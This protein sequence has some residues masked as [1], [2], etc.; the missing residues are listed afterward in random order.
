MFT[1]F[2]NY[3]YSTKFIF[4]KFHKLKQLQIIKKLYVFD[5]IT[6]S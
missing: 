5:K 4:H 3:T 1:N 2:S 6:S